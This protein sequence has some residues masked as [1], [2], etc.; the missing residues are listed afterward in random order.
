MTKALLCVECFDIQSPRRDGTWRYCECGKSATRWRDGPRGLIEVS[1]RYSASRVRVIGL[2][3]GF[4]TKA[5]V[6]GQ[7]L[8]PE[9]WR[10]LHQHE[11]DTVPPGYLFHADKR[12]CWA[13]IVRVGESGDIFYVDWPQT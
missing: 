5:I 7:H 8:N 3:N 13:L 1:S 9:M 12:A 11:A 4:I 2:N 6:Q 10:E